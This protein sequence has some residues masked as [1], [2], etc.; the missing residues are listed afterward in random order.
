M[1]LKVPVRQSVFKQL[2][3][4]LILIVPFV[5][6]ISVAVGLTGGFRL[7]RDFGVSTAPTGPEK[8]VERSAERGR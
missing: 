3:L 6:Q 1:A 8:S 4:R 5:L 2:S 7:R